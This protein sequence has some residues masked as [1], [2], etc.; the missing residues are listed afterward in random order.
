M[1][2]KLKLDNGGNSR[3]QKQQKNKEKKN[4][5]TVIA[6]Q[7]EHG[8]TPSAGKEQAEPAAVRDPLS[9]PVCTGDGKKKERSGK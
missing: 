9:T 3:A 2:F 1:I 6:F 7:V 5:I 4:K 8:D